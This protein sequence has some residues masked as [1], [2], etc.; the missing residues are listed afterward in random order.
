MRTAPTRSDPRSFIFKSAA[1]TPEAGPLQ[2][3]RDR[4][5][6][7]Q[8]HPIRAIH[9]SPD[10]GSARHRDDRRES[11]PCPRPQT[12]AALP[13]T[14]TMMPGGPIAALAQRTGQSPESRFRRLYCPG[15]SGRVRHLLARGPTTFRPRLLQLQLFEERR[16]A[17]DP[18]AA[19]DRRK[20]PLRTPQVLPVNI[21]RRV[22]H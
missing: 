16:A 15:R 20:G 18:R 4:S 14:G 17:L 12:A 11:G 1:D 21:S 9:P 8:E 6:E 2:A 22:S 3:R 10:P 7:A 13:S 19:S 5:G